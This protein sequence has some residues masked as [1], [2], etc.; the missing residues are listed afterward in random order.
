MMVTGCGGY[1]MMVQLMK[2]VLPVFPL[3]TAEGGMVSSTKL[4]TVVSFG[5]LPSTI[6]TMHGTS[7]CIT[8]V[9]VWPKEISTI[10]K[11]ALVFVV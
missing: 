1:Q 11:V 6:V 2:V 3:V 9:R 7:S 8:G 10:S 5:R 4:C